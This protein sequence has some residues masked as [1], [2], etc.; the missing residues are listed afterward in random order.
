MWNSFKIAFSMYSKIPMPKTDWNKENMKYAL[1]FFP[2]VGL[3]IGII[4]YLWSLLAKFLALG[5]IFTTAIYTIIPILITGGIHMDGFVDSM[6]AIN[7]YQSIERKLEILK[8]SHIGAFA[9][10]TS[11]TY[12]IA[13]FGVLSEI[14]GEEII[15]V[16]LGFI[17][18]RALSGLSIVTFPLAKKSGLAANFSDSAQKKKVKI[19][20]IIYIIIISLIMLYINLFLGIAS[21]IS[22]LIVFFYYKLMAK[23]KFG[24]ITG[25]I[26]G[27]FLQLCELF[28][29][30]ALVLVGKIF[31]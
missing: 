29:A 24:G 30:L 27:Y 17:L 19:T 15:I 2:L 31:L 25:D 22:S 26:A 9:L 8:D 28:I 18:S 3:A 23:K 4:F 10:I 14:K 16:S 5:N 20:M 7:S 11:I 12:F 21:I 6:D 13:Y 1:C